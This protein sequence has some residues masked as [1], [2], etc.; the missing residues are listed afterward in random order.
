MIPDSL[1]WRWTMLS[2]TFLLSTVIF[3]SVSFGF[4]RFCFK[5][6]SELPLPRTTLALGI[7]HC[8]TWSTLTLVTEP[9]PGALQ[10]CQCVFQ[11]HRVPS[12]SNILIFCSKFRGSYAYSYFKLS[13]TYAW[14]LIPSSLLSLFI[15]RII[16]SVMIYMLVFRILHD[17]FYL[18]WV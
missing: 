3:P 8:S 12:R 10:H 6:C 16:E 17:S 9:L 5:C 13:E 18:L 14:F 11:P 1:L 4:P 15:H 2:R 7:P